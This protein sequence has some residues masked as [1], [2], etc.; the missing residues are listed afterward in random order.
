MSCWAWSH[1]QRPWHPK[2]A[3]R[4]KISCS[5]LTEQPLGGSS[6]EQREGR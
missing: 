6:M 5:V 3:A 1:N 2:Y 4:V